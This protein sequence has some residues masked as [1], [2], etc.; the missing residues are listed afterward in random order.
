L[1]TKIIQP[2]HAKKIKLEAIEAR[3]NLLSLIDQGFLIIYLDEFM[4]T[5]QTIPTHEWTPKNKVY[6][7]DYKLYHTK[8]IAS[9]AAISLESGPELIMNFDKSVD[10]VKFI[11]FLR[12]LRKLH[13]GRKLALFFDQ[14]KV[15]TA[16]LCRPVYEELDI[17][18]M[19]N[20]SYSPSYN[21]IEGMF[22]VTKT[23][24][25][26]ERLRALALNKEINL[27]RVIKESFMNIDKKVC[28]NFINCSN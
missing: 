23:K 13:P 9:E 16:K 3:A 4:T 17:K 26:R 11:L 8:T 2:D 19:H 14:L 21:P 10:A 20:S 6:Q 24:I 28:V 1:R 18:W 25:K 15:H 27:D 12:A 5:K 22:S 7:I